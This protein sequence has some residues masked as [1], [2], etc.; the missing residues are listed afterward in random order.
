MIISDHI[1]VFCIYSKSYEYIFNNFFLKTIS[2]EF[3]SLL[4]QYLLDLDS[5]PGQVTEPNFQMI[6]YKKLHLIHKQLKASEG[7]ILLISDVDIIFLKEIAEDIISLM[8]E[9]DVLV[10]DNGNGEYNVGFTAI[11]CSPKTISFWEQYVLPESEKILNWTVVGD[12]PVI[13]HCLR[14]NE[15]GII[16]DALPPRYWVNRTPYDDNEYRHTFNQCVEEVP[17]DAVLFHPVAIGHDTSENKIK[18]FNA[19]LEKYN[20]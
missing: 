12:Q 17:N 2:K 19:V 11:K 20:L 16:H 9:K 3:S 18:L 10:A 6:N 5:L 4:T 7:K 13:N 8:D 15:L 14:N 1:D